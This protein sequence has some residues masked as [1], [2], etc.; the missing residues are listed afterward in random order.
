MTD[1][2]NLFCGAQGGCYVID[3][4][5]GQSFGEPQQPKSNLKTGRRFRRLTIP[6]W[7]AYTA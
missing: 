3:F 2:F 6:E 4:K 1:N 5:V 7:T